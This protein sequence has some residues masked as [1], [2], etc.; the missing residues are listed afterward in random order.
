MLKWKRRAVVGSSL[1]DDDGVS[2]S[3]N[4]VRAA[5]SFRS[6]PGVRHVLHNPFT[7]FPPRRIPTLISSPARN[8]PCA[9][10]GSLTFP[11]L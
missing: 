11:I 4:Q 10:R 2:P 6:N 1:R 9:Q 3:I 7:N 5:N 8:A